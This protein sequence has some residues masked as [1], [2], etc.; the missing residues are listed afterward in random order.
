MNSTNGKPW[1][2]VTGAAGFIGSNLARALLEKYNVIGVDNF[3]SYYDSS[4]KRRNLAGIKGPHSFIFLE[5]DITNWTDTKELPQLEGIFHLAAQPGVRDS[6]QSG[7]RSYAINNVLGTQQILDLA[8]RTRTK[9]FIY[10]SSSSVYGD[11]FSTPTSETDL[12]SPIS[13]YG[14][15]KL[16]GELLADSYAKTSSLKVRSLRYFTVYGPGQRPD[17]AIFRLIEKTLKGELFTQ[18]GDGSQSRDFTYI[19]DVVRANILALEQPQEL[20]SEVFNVGGGDGINLTDL[21]KCIEGIVGKSLEINFQPKSQG[22]V[23]ITKADISNIGRHLGWSPR[24]KLVDGLNKQV[25]WQQGLRSSF[26]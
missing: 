23:H 22:D 24:V 13:P 21:V 14:V 3:H 4:A 9:R 19:D 5:Q 25:Q 16:T 6:W 26:V 17:M 1:V 18:Y 12:K 10:S 11:S 2:L 7:F 20:P 15:S 8:V